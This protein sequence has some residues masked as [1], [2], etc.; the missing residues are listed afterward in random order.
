MAKYSGQFPIYK[1][2]AAAQF[3]Y[4][5]LRRDPKGNVSKNGGIL[6]EV[7]PALT[8]DNYDW[9]QKISFAFGIADLCRL[10][11]NPEAP[12][13]LVHETPNSTLIKS[14]EFTPGTGN[15]AG[16]YMMKVSETDS[17]DKTK[18]KFC[19]V[20]LSSGEYRVMMKLFTDLS[21]TMIGWDLAERD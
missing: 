9:S 10:M 3:S 11:E 13:R 18:K 8:E 5:P 19:Q 21:S 17:A 4:I 12:P 6:V 1:N 15:F 7:A 20:P 16:T 14:L 2:K